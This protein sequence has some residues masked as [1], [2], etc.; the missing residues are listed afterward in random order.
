MGNIASRLVSECG[1]LKLQRDPLEPRWSHPLSLHS[2]A[3]TRRPCGQPGERPPC[4][5]ESEEWEVLWTRRQ[6]RNEGVIKEAKK[7]TSQRKSQS[8]REP[9]ILSAVRKQ[10]AE[11]RHSSLLDSRPFCFAHMVSL[12]S[13]ITVLGLGCHAEIKEVE[14]RGEE[15][16][17]ALP[18]I[19]RSI[20]FPQGS[21][22]T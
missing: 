12:V 7:K 10:V 20:L 2:E 13:S 17:K 21:G 16:R 8:M 15:W 3:G 19:R 9:K 11:S 18:F 14:E 5:R 22:W 1:G 4:L 6:D